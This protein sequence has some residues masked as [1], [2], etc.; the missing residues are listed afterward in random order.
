M[1]E[2]SKKAVGSVLT[3]AAHSLQ[4][5]R[6]TDNIASLKLLPDFHGVVTGMDPELEELSH[7]VG[8]ALHNRG[9]LLVTA[10]SCTGGWVAQ[11]ITAV[12]G[13]SGWFERGCVTYS[14]AAKQEMLGVH[15]ETLEAW[16][17]VSEQTIREMVEGALKRSRAQIGVAISGIAGPTGGTL[18][19]PVGTVWLAWAIQ[20]KPTQ[21]RRFVLRGDRESV[22]QQA[23]VLALQGILEGLDD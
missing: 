16:G 14:N 11:V 17:A 13:S 21:A 19:K 3:F 10:E 12:P 6:V 23:V 22:R 15:K 1:H 20:G 7:Q 8:V 2:V 18:E 4:V 5:W 9:M